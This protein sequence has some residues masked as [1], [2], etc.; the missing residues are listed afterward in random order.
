MLRYSKIISVLAR[1]G[2]GSFLQELQVQKYIPLP[3]KR[4]RQSP[5]TPGISQA[6]HFRLALE[7][8]GPTFIKLGQVLSTR[9]DLLPAD[10]IL[11]LYKLCDDVSPTPW[12]QIEKV[13]IAQYGKPIDQ[14][15][16][17]FD[18]HPLGSASLAQV[19]AACLFDG[20]PVVVKVQR[21]NISRTIDADL[22]IL[23]DL[24]TL[25]QRTSWGQIYRPVEIVSRFARTLRSELDYRQEGLNA[26][27]FSLQFASERRLKIPK[28]EWE[29]SGKNVLVME[30]ISGIKIDDIQALQQ[31]NFNCCEVAEISIRVVAKEIMED[32]FFHADPHPGNFFVMHCW[33]KENDESDSET[34]PARIGVLDFGMVGYISDTD[35]MNIV[36]CVSLAVKK[37]S[38]GLVDQMLRMGAI[39]AKDDPSGLEREIDRLINQYQGLAIK[40]I[41]AGRLIQDM[42]QV[43]FRYRIQLPADM[44][45]LFKTIIELDG[46]AR[47]L[48]PEI[49]VFQAFEPHVRKIMHD[50]FLPWVWGPVFM[51][52]LESLAYASRDIPSIAENLLRTLQQGKFPLSFN[53]G[54]DKD[55]L[56]RM[57]RMITRLTL[58]MLAS[59]FILGLAL[60]LPIASGNRVA[61][62]LVAIGFL[63]ALGLGGW[64]AISILKK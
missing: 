55:T 59:A 2:F 61:S 36:Q 7:E 22:D 46:L 18:L 64:L 24:A 33:E 30:R 5:R 25:A 58:S 10:Y 21:P 29:Y 28:I 62:A 27:R 39:S 43:A 35:R 47:Q 26:E 32:G 31:A 37:D 45:L 52:D 50:K 12:D 53:M 56:G 34:C 15:F 41:H 49:N 20:R 17:E 8:L 54:M 4:L 13:L 11:Q 60:L 6:E 51:N 14:V 42:M 19:H 48:D 38:R 57:D 23:Y 1:H 44:W 9:P 3:P 63:V 40:Q 16:S